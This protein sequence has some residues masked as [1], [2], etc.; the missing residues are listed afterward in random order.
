MLIF[1]A[2]IVL[3][4]ILATTNYFDPKPITL[5]P[6]SDALYLDP[7]QP[8][9]ARV[10]DLVSY[11]TLEEKI[12][13]MTLVEK[14]SLRTSGDITTFGLGAL[15]SGSGAKPDENNAR[16]W[17]QMIDN[18]QTEALKSR[19]HIP[20]LYGSDA[21]HGHAHVPEAT[22]FPHMIALGATG[23]SELVKEIAK[24]TADELSATGVNWNFAPNLD[25]PQ[26][27]RWGRVYE[28]I[29]DDPELVA[30]LG[31]AYLQGLHDN[32]DAAAGRIHVLATPKHFI[33]LG[34]MG[35]NTSLNKSFKIDQGV[36]VA[37][38]KLLRSTYLPPFIE[39]IDAGALSIMV[40]LN[41]WG[42]ERTVRQKELLTD[43]LKKELGFKG[44]IVS[45]W[46]GVHEGTHNTFL[47]TVKAVNAGV[48]MVMLPFD[49][50]TFIRHM[51]W[52]NRFG[53]ISDE[54]ID[55][56]VR[57]ILYAK[58]A[59]GLFDGNNKSS[60]LSSIP[61][62]VH[63]ALAREAVAQ[64]LVLLKNENDTLPLKTDTKKIHVAGSA[65]DNVGQQMGAWSIEWQ[66]I[67]GNWLS[68]ATSILEGIQ[69]RSEVHGTK[70]EYNISGNFSSN[71]NM[72]DVGIAIVGERPYAEGWGDKE[73]PTLSEEDA[74]A[75]KNLQA[76]SKKLVVIIVSGRPLLV[77][78]ELD[79]F[80]AL[81]V[82]W[83]PG[84]EGAGVTDVLFG[85]KQFTGTLPLPWPS[86]I[87]QLPIT[88]TGETRD[89]SNVLFPRYFGLKY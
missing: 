84:S 3:L 62:D 68:G 20:L 36:T 55:D 64:S 39:A 73:Y 21:I 27:I 60:K 23:N 38:E 43:V 44:F 48:D 18:Y 14:N 16:G 74:I 13:Q 1:I 85:K 59:L 32:A 67:D 47:A 83:L 75:I 40:G 56:A 77:E 53:L 15:L 46:Y 81:V 66:G 30:K 78:D 89:G 12:G 17:K 45:D 31:V 34:G 52:A 61:N 76:N 72:A 88:T 35:W 10:V 57:R 19:L 37:D 8:I 26:D 2:L 42:D 71:E 80:D 51:K 7:T 50:K 5:T 41:N 25:T 24:A 29:S 69:K 49:Y 4:T 79:L 87:S 28:A 54:R 82:A 11:M 65:A 63:R 9:E 22:V 6:P 58:F 33:G 86:H 70:V